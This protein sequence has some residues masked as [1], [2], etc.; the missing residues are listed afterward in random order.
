MPNTE[1]E[2]PNREEE[3]DTGFCLK[4]QEE[5]PLEEGCRHPKDYCPHR[6]ACLL[7]LVLKEK[8]RRNHEDS[9]NQ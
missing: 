1:P 5:V 8:R 4:F 9:H 2:T 7:N 3:M 6:T